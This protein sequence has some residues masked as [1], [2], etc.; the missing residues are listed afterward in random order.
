MRDNLQ[1]ALLWLLEN[2]EVGAKHQMATVCTEFKLTEAE[3]ELV[4]IALMGKQ[5]NCKIPVGGPWFKAC[6]A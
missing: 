4:N 1:K 3:K 2:G 5:E 6:T